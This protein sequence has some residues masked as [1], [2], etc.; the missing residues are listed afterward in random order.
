MNTFEWREKLRADLAIFKCKSQV[1]KLVT[2]CERRDVIAQDIK[3]WR[4]E[5]PD[6][7]IYG[8]NK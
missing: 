7:I 2:Q 3:K 5:N 4:Q 8:G 1:K 6:K